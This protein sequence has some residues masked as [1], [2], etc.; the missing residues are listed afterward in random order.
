LYFCKITRRL[1]D[2]IWLSIGSP[3]LWNMDWPFFLTASLFRGI[4]MRFSRDM[5]N[6]P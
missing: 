2:L 3:L 5:H 4:F 6:V 1:T